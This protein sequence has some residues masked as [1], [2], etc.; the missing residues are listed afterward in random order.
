LEQTLSSSEHEPTPAGDT[1]VELPRDPRSAAL[2]RRFVDRQLRERRLPEPVVE[3]ALLISSELVTNAF[4]HGEGKI[5]LKLCLLP[6]RVRVEVIDEG[7]RQAPA[8][9]EQPGDETGGWGLKI[10]E[11]VA[12]RWGVFEGTTHVWADLSLS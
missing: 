1:S 6:D 8:V 12:L 3:R 5:E 10:V 4:K 7:H 11:R 2:A 9:R